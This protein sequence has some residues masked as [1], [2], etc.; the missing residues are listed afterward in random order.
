MSVLKSFGT[1]PDGSTVWLAEIGR[2][3]GLK[4]SIITYGGI[5][6]SVMVPDK[7]GGSCDVILGKQTL[8]NYLTDPSSSAAVIGRVANRIGGA[9]FTL[10]G[11]TYGLLANDRGNCLHGGGGMY[12][13]KNFTVAGVTESSVKLAHFDNGEGGFPGEV[14]VTVTYSVTEDDELSIEYRAAATEDTP[15]NLTNHVYFNLAG[16]GSGPI[17]EQELQI[18]AEFYTPANDAVLPTGEIAKVEGTPLDFRRLRAFGPAFAELDASGSPLGG[19]DHNFVLKGSG[20]RRVA[21]ACD[22]ASGRYMETYT[23]LPGVQLYTANGLAERPGKDAAVYNKHGGFCLETQFF[24]DSINRP[25]FPEAL[26]K[27]DS[28][29]TSRT[30]YRFG[31]E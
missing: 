25:H 14:D 22:P 26:L 4:V 28:V 3:G 7:E 27:K 20:Y 15:I 31:T 30:A 11:K 24:P 2:P 16:H 1:L 6:H 8:E 9:S 13:N 10:G 19:F 17:D 21:L 12:A 29:F 18:D 23:D 5:I